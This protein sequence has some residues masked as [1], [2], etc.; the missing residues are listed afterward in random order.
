VLILGGVLLVAAGLVLPSAWLSPVEPD[1]AR[2][3]GIWFFRAVS[4]LLGF[5]LVA[6]ARAIGEEPPAKRP[7]ALPLLPLV[8]LL[9]LAL[10]V[11]LIGLGSD[12][13]YDE[14]VSLTEFVRLPVAD[15]L[16][17]YT[18]QNNHI[19][20][21][22][23]AKAAIALLGE[24]PAAVRLPAVLFGVASVAAVFA[25]GRRIASDREALLASALVALSY[26][27][28]WFSQNARGYTGLMFLGVVATALF[29]DGLRER[30]RRLWVAY[31][32]TFAAAMYVHLSAVFLFTCHG[33]VYVG[34]FVWGL[35]SPGLARQ[36][37]GA[38]DAWPLLGFVLGGLMVL[39]LHAL[40]LP[41]MF[42]TFGRTVGD[43]TALPKVSPWR[44]PLWTLLEAI[45]QLP[46][47]FATA[48]GAALGAGLGA[49]AWW[50]LM[51]RDPAAAWLL[52][53]PFP[54]TLGTLV[55]AGFH[56][57]PRYFFQYLGFAA[58]LL[59][60]GAFVIV[61]RLPGAR[62]RGEPWGR[63]AAT[64]LV[65]ALIVG[66]AATLP[67]NYRTPK[68][69]F[70]QAREFVESNRHP[71]EVVVTAGLAT[72]PYERLYAPSWSSVDD[73]REL[74]G[75]ERESRGTWLVYSF[76]TYMEVAHEDILQAAEERYE[77]RAVFPGTLG[78][79][80]L[81]VWHRSGP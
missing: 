57:W 5:S 23:S 75:V 19:L 26:H 6:T 27:H 32:A 80:A 73:A 78:D 60:Q 69:P 25:F 62:T 39:E 45:R 34:L 48:A 40:I 59:V 38:R 42:E 11:R 18:V 10:V 77:E 46:G 9:A 35:R 4:V 12:L 36:Y 30:R 76:P 50:Q 1:A 24:A 37:P 71:G 44:S 61:P 20:Y 66:S 70:S 51:R 22:L 2:L 47:G 16:T 56:I 74:A 7:A 49:W 79:G 3:Q 68:Q 31:A 65:L 33:L 21:S 43:A 28:V 55:V 81:F 63:R 14:V 8:T 67:A 64:V 29:V 52:A 15:L 53:L 54:L 58:L 13:W 72:L 17:T 41:Q